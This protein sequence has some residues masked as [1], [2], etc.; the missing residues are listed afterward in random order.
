MKDA[1]PRI[2]A[3]SKLLRDAG[4]HRRSQLALRESQEQLIREVNGARTL[5]AISTRLISE[6]TQDALFA[7]VLD[8]AMELMGADAAGLQMLAPDGKSLILLG[9]KNF[10]PA[11]VAHWREVPTDGACTCAMAHR[12]QQRIIVGD[13]EACEFLEDTEDLDEYRRSGIRAFQIM[14]LLSRAGQPLG[15]ISTH[16][17][18]PHIPTDGD[19]RLFDVLAR[20][21]AD[22]IERTRAETTLRISETKYRSLFENMDEA[23]YLVEIVRD[24]D[25][26]P[27]DVIYLDENAAGIRLV[28]L[29]VKGRR[30]SEVNAGA[31]PEW[32]PIFDRVAQ[33]GKPERFEKVVAYNGRWQHFHLFPAGSGKDRVGILAKDVTGRKLAEAKLLESEEKFR[34]IANTSP[35]IIW[36]ADADSK[37]VFVNQP[38][39]EFTGQSLEEALSDGGWS[40][41]I[42][43][44]DVPTCTAIFRHARE[45]L[46]K[47]QMEFRLRRA[48]GEYRWIVS[49]S[50]PRFHEDKTFAGYVGSSI[51]VTERRQAEE[52]LATINQRLTDAQEDER[53]R[54]ARELHDDVVQRLVGLGWR[55]GA[56][57]DPA[58]GSQNS[59]PEIESVRAEIMGLAKDVQALSH[60][61]H[62]AWMEFLGVAGA[63]RALCRE[64]SRRSGID[65]ACHIE[66]IPD[67]LSRD[68]AVC[69]HR[70]LQEAL[71]NAIKHSQSARVEVSLRS[72]LNEIEMTVQDFGVGFD[73]VARGQGLGLTSMKER[74][75]AIGG[76]L[77]IF[78]QPNGTTIQ[79]YAPI[80]QAETAQ[81]E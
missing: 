9:W 74:L 26:R 77:S 16:W 53:S 22:L 80:A 4:E 54:I 45:R 73:P 66:E 42:H 17:R 75:K 50:A 76:R 24:K 69:L 36:M 79:A 2:I 39:L 23:F 8:A 7:H 13:V 61:L 58:P 81:P 70:V 14:P 48:D 30:L 62:P 28:G 37:C 34:A 31:V 25:G 55:L 3:A 78:S 1:D 64:V 52:A 63:V 40:A 46:E 67:G 57:S 68:N 5:Q 21:A 32:L 49:S 33:T 51:D 72:V 6:V 20:Q 38:W 19:L 47:C 11:A 18:N 59:I 43:P 29:S 27:A 60:R 71:Q 12:E 10:P 35:V 65:I 44:D 41:R 15:M 56:A